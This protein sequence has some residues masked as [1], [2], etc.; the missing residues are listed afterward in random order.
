[1]LTLR[2]QKLIAISGGRGAAREIV[3]F[4][5]RAGSPALPRPAQ[6]KSRRQSAMLQTVAPWMGLS[7]VGLGVLASPSYAS[8]TTIE[9]MP[10]TLET[11]FALSAV[12]PALRGASTVIFLIPRW[13]INFLDKEPVV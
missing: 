7:I 5:V 8:E 13:A 10:A 6:L 12:P 1:M 9:Q 3:E 11:Q 4:T 2:G